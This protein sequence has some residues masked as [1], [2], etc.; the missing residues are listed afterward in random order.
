MDVRSIIPLAYYLR[1]QEISERA[2]RTDASKTRTHQ[3]YPY[4]APE[5]IVE[6]TTAEENS[7]P[8]KDVSTG[9]PLRCVA[10]VPRQLP[11]KGSIIDIWV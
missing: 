3:P 4:P 1:T 8:D 2:W 5:D 6:I 10:M 11:A 9:E 7:T